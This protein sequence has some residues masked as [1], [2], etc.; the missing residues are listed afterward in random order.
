[1]TAAPRRCRKS[2]Q[3][4]GKGR[5]AGAALGAVSAGLLVLSACDKPTPLATVT[6]GTNSV[7]AEAACYADGDTVPNKKIASC[8]E[9]KPDATI[10]MAQGDTL[11]LGVEPAIAETGWV[12][13]LNGAPALNEPY[14]KTYRSFAGIDLFASQTGGPAAKSVKLSILEVDANGKYKGAW[15]F[16]I[17]K[18][19]G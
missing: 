8:V 13:Y 5:R 15:N 10:K 7:N 3:L 12:L 14:K 6:V 1:M 4:S 9:K 19:N 18:D 16:K 11:R 2:I 17:E